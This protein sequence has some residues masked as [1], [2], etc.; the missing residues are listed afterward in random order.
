[1]PDLAETSGIQFVATRDQQIVTHSPRFSELP[2]DLE[3]ADMGSQSAKIEL[4]TDV[5][6]QNGLG[7][8]SDMRRGG[9]AK[10]RHATRSV[11][12]SLGLRQRPSGLNT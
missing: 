11:R 1:M 8:D 9:R 2:W 4:L 12:A 6:S 7:F 3:A 5:A 10:S